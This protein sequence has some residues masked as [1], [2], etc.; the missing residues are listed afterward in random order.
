[1][2]IQFLESAFNEIRNT[3]GSQRIETG[4]ILLGNRK[5]WVVQK[6]IFDPH[7]STF[8]AGYDPDVDFINGTLKKEWEKNELS[9]LGFVH[10]HPRGFARLSGDYGNNTG[11]IGYLKAIFEKI[12]ALDRFLV[13]IVFSQYDG[14]E[15]E[16][17]PFVAWADDVNEYKSEDYEVVKDDEYYSRKETFI[18]SEKSQKKGLK[19]SSRLVGAVDVQLM[20]KAHVIGIG[21][22]GAS[23]IY[24]NLVR[25][26]LGKLTIVD[27]DKI[28][29]S[30]ITTQGWYLDEVGMPKVEALKKRLLRINPDVVVECLQEDFLKFND[31][32]IKNLFGDCNLLMMMTDNFYAQAKGNEVSLKFKVPA[33]WAMMYEKARASEIVFSIP[34]VT[35]ACFRC[36]VA[37]RYKAYYDEGYVNDVKSAGSTIFHTQYLNQVIGM[38]SL[39]I[40]HN[41][42]TGNEF[43]NWFGKQWDKNFIQIRNH[44]KY[45][46]EEGNLFAKTFKG[47]E[48]VFNFDAIWH[49]MYQDKEPKSKDC[50]DCVPKGF[51][52]SYDTFEM[53]GN[54]FY[55][56]YGNRIGEM[57]GNQHYDNYGNRL[58]EMRGNQYYDN[59]GNRM[60]EMR[61]NNNYYDNYGNRLGEMRGNRFYDQYGNF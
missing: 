19:D 47:I 58:G 53:R 56:R 27:F 12:P 4:G 28:D 23:N 60:G 6:F 24:E 7:G 46:A 18:L 57:R 54:Q 34:G 30:N 43:S 44:P 5:D 17:I 16:L 55:D 22:G 25:S 29:N 59:Y 48:S 20:G 3:V 51:F 9:L 31:K 45:S 8:P 61:D 11:D 1:M 50:P 41:E 38:V 14:K 10:S 35:P 42:T 21:V 32:K 37:P 39:A 13:P 49:K 36:C 33:I 52:R 40:L 26:G 2:K 15:F